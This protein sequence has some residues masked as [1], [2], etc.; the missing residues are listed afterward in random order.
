MTNSTESTA[1]VVRLGVAFVPTMAPESLRSYVRAAEEA[2]L[3][4]FWVWEDCFKQS[5]L[6]SAAAALAFTERIRVGVGL[7]PVPLRNVAL[8]AMEVATLAR[9]FPGRFVAG[10]G[11]GVQDWMGQAGARVESPMTL[12]REYTSALRR[13]L[14]GEE[15]S[16]EGRYITL[17]GVRLD[18]PPTTVPPLLL[19]GA[20][21]K[22]LRLAAEL[23]DGT[24]LATALTDGEIG[25]I[26]EL[27]RGVRN[28]ADPAVPHDIV[29]CHITATGPGAAE[30]LEREVGIWR[31]TPAEGPVGVA[32]DAA[33]VAASLRRLADAGITAVAIQPTADEPDV[34]AFVRF[35]GEEVKPLLG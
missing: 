34:A 27:V 16:V 31:T 29:A 17:D 12:L 2:G 32:G 15:V 28:E 14:A 24:L 21:P 7:M 18:W 10:V 19:G 6:A 1:P 8:T 3:D 23:G 20:G 35:L 26:C 5:G 9:Q 4:E 30:R 13:L 25:G 33:E 11:H 22:T